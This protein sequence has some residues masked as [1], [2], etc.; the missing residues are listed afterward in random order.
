MEATWRYLPSLRC[1]GLTI[2]LASMA[3]AVA[4]GIHRDRR[5]YGG[6]CPPRPPLLR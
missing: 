4:L 1:L 6:N 2:V 3:L 5:V